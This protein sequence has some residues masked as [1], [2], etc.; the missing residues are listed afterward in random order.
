MLSAAAAVGVSDWPGEVVDRGPVFGVREAE[1]RDD[2]QL[3]LGLPHELEAPLKLEERK[4]KKEGE[5]K[6]EYIKHYK[7]FQIR[8][9]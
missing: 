6:C 8:L 4:E 5:Y 7:R 2:L 9:L 1:L 3:V